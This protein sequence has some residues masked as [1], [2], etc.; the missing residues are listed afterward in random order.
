MRES[1]VQAKYRAVMCINK[2]ISVCPESPKDSDIAAVITYTKDFLALGDLEI[3]ELCHELYLK[4]LKTY[5][6]Q[7]DQ[8]LEMICDATLTYIRS[9]DKELD[10]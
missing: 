3:Y 7:A 10:A 5:Y 2:T 9:D 8:F 1:T 4:I 6:N